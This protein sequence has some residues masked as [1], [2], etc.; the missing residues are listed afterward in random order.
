MFV[1]IGARWAGNG[2]GEGVDVAVG[3]SIGDGA[4]DGV[5]VGEEV[6]VAVARITVGSGIIVGVGIATAA[7]TG[8]G[9]TVEVITVGETVAGPSDA[10]DVADPAP[11]SV[12][13]VLA[14]IDVTVRSEAGMAV[15]VAVSCSVMAVGGTSAPTPPC[16]HATAPNSSSANDTPSRLLKYCCTSIIL[17]ISC[18]FPQRECL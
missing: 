16:V 13:A 6:A 17:L 15:D 4:V 1:P 12:S 8:V 10:V 11:V 5:G 14:A 18:A 9:V 2:V 3:T 7:G